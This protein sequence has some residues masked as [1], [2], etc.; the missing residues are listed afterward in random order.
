MWTGQTSQIQTYIQRYSVYGHLMCMYNVFIWI[1]EEISIDGIACIEFF[2]KF[3]YIN[4]IMTIIQMRVSCIKPQ[5][6]KILSPW[7]HFESSTIIH[8]IVI[9][10]YLSSHLCHCFFSWR[11]LT[12][13]VCNWLYNFI[14]FTCERIQAPLDA[15]R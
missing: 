3:R 13:I 4:E 5:R 6:S 1:S 11:Y 15:F 7:K 14:H 10:F 8:G 12:H 9:Y 2:N